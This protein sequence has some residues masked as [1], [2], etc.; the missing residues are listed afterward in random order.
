MKKYYITYVNGGS[1]TSWEI[2]RDTIGEVKQ[3]IECY[4]DKSNVRIS[5]IDRILGDFIF[6]KDI[7]ESPDIDL[8][9]NR[10]SDLRTKTRLAI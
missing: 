2:E 10:K 1:G 8:I 6:W 5:V 3:E 4:K 7:F 9:Y